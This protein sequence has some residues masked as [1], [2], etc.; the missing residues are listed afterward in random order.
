MISHAV[1]LAIFASVVFILRAFP[2]GRLGTTLNRGVFGAALVVVGPLNIAWLLV[3]GGA[4]HGHPC[5]GY[6][7][8]GLQLTEA[9]EV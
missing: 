6:P 4:H 9:P 5:A 7:V 3:G 1:H 2:S 8:T